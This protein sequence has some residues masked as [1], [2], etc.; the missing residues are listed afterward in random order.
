[1]SSRFKRDPMTVMIRLKFSTVV[2]LVRS[3]Y[4]SSSETNGERSSSRRC[5]SST[6]LRRTIFLRCGKVRVVGLATATVRYAERNS[7]KRT[8]CR[9]GSAWMSVSMCVPMIH[10]S[11]KV[12]NPRFDA[13]VR[14]S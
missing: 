12:E 9:S 8:S 6:T 4:N 7:S 5:D 3:M 2:K 13:L 10:V 11:Y 1:M 14:R